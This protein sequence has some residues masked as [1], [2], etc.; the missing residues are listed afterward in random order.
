METNFINSLNEIS[1]GITDGKFDSEAAV[2]RGIIMR[3]LGLLGWNIFDTQFVYPEFPLSS[4]KVDYALC[5]PAGK[6]EAIIEV[7][8]IGKVSG[9]DDQLFDYAFKAGGIPIAVLTDGKEWQFYYPAG[10]GTISDRC[11]L[12]FDITKSKP[13]NIQVKMESFLKYENICDG[14][15]AK[16]AKEA[17]DLSRAKA[18]SRDYI[19][20]AFN[21]LIEN[22][23][24]ILLDL[25]SKKVFELCNFNPNKEDIGKYLKSL[26]INPV[27]NTIP[28]NNPVSIQ[29]NNANATGRRNTFYLNG[30]YVQKNSA[31]DVIIA[32]FNKL[33]FCKRQT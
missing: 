17:Y 23:N 3:L 29:V 11:F 9:G 27:S 25:I 19:P 6:P 31:I 14:N 8:A 18:L 24:E 7:K 22:N 28:I 20:K 16:N 30:N 33:V 26:R 12:K 2:S 15:A 4:R 5:Y 32:L 21:E 13:E 1:K 10:K